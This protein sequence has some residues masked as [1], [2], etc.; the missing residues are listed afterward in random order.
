MLLSARWLWLLKPPR[1]FACSSPTV[2]SGLT[3]AVRSFERSA[4]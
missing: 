2:T 1:L 3:A 4:L